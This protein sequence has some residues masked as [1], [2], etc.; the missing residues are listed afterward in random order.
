[1]TVSPLAWAAQE[2]SPEASSDGSYAGAP[3]SSDR[4]RKVVGLTD[5]P[6]IRERIFSEIYLDY[7]DSIYS[8]CLRRLGDPVLAEDVVQDTF[9][10]AY[11][12]L[13]RFD[14]SKPIL[15]WLAVIAGRRCIDVQR[16]SQNARESATGS[17]AVLCSEVLPAECGSE[18]EDA[19]ERLPEA[20]RKVLLLR[21]HHDMTLAEIA[22]IEG[23]SAVV[24]KGLLQRARESVR[25]ALGAYGTA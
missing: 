11:Q 21:A 18:V 16:R 10:R 19:V 15:P 5:D 2:L 20:Q 4:A 17:P 7:R 14:W 6:R 22:A 25:R 9:L 3:R 8:L 1:M 13:W 23:T 24:V 12:N